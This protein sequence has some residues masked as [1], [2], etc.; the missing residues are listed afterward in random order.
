MLAALI[1]GL[2]DGPAYSKPISSEADL[3]R[4]IAQLQQWD[5][6]PQAFLDLIEFAGDSKRDGNGDDPQLD[7]M[8]AKAIEAI[9]A[10]PNL[11]GVEP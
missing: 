2:L 8:H 11:E 10:C 6:R 7:R 1:V 5:T 9:S 4:V 3:A